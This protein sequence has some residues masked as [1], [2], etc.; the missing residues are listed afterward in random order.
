MA[1][2]AAVRLAAQ[3]EAESEAWHRAHDPIQGPPPPIEHLGLCAECFTVYRN[4]GW[5]ME[6]WG[7]YH[8][9]RPVAMD[10]SDTDLC[11]HAC[12]GGEPC[13]W[14]PIAFAAAG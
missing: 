14:L 7:A 8:V 4:P 10:P 11:F 3:R 5:F 9:E 1:A 6:P 12:H 2:K 13:C